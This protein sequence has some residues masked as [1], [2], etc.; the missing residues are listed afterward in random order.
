MT[1]FG[2][3]IEIIFNLF[4]SFIGIFLPSLEVLHSKRY[5]YIWEKWPFALKKRRNLKNIEGP[6]KTQLV[7]LFGEALWEIFYRY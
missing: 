6:S 4:K 3:S 2:N 5:N 1:N 7:F